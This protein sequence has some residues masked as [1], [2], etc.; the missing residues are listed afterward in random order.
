MGLIYNLWVKWI[1]N[2]VI[3]S[4][5][6]K[7]T[8][9]GHIPFPA[10]TICPLTKATPD[11]FNYTKVYRALLKL[12]GENSE[13]PTQD[14][15]VV[16]TTV[17]RL[18]FLSNYFQYWKLDFISNL[19][20]SIYIFNILRLKIMKAASQICDDNFA[21]DFRLFSDNFTDDSILTIFKN[22]MPKME[23]TMVSRLFCHKNAL[24]IIVCTLIDLLHVV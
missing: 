21:R 22:I 16:S 11:K 20:S 4:F 12:D 6:H 8:S 7:V 23:D 2:P 19:E 13:T 1:E 24:S 17:D 18:H 10:M 5:D 3:V 9:I 15:Y 14:E